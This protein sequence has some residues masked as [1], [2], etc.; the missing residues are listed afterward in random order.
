MN[1]ASWNGTANEVVDS[2]GA[3]KHGVALAG[4]STTTGKIGNGGNFN[5]ATKIVNLSSNVSLASSFTIAVWVLF[6]IPASAS[7]WRT[8]VRGSLDHPVLVDG[9]GVWGV[10]DNATGTGFR[11]S[12]FN[13]NSLSGWHHLVAVGSGTT[14]TFYGDGS[15]TPLGTSPFKSNNAV[16]VFGNYSGGSQNF[17]RIDELGIWNRALTTGEIATLYNGGSGLTWY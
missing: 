10:Y 6:P 15:S 17:G 5:T 8:L 4:A 13:L 14:T 2:S 9:G 3:G 11:S 16:S 12:G 7:G 1:E